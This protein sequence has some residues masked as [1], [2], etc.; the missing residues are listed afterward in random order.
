MDVFGLPNRVCASIRKLPKSSEK[1]PIVSC[2]YDMDKDELDPATTE[3]AVG[4]LPY[5][6]IGSCILE[7]ET[8]N[9]VADFTAWEPTDWCQ[10]WGINLYGTN[11]TF[12]GVLNPAVG[13]ITLRSD[14][15]GYKQGKTEITPEKGEGV[16]NQV[17]YYARQIDLL[18][19]RAKTGEKTVSAGLPIQLNLMKVVEAMYAS[20]EQGK[21]IIVQ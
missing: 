1:H 10:D 9:V 16:S 15:A 5:E 12:H 20:A 2:W 21:F 14:K 11:G 13:Q 18:L 7:Y 3:Y 6:D 17:G 4:E 19:R 8:H